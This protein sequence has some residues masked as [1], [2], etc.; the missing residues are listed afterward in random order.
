MSGRWPGWLFDNLGLKAF[1]LLLAALLYLHVLTDRTVEK[2]VYF[3]L[4]IESLPDSLALAKQVP[5]E[6]GV[7]LRGT[8]K[9]L[10]RLQYTRPKL[11]VSLAGVTPGAFRRPFAATDVPLEGAEAVDVLEITDPPQ[12]DLEVAPRLDRPVPIAP[13]LVGQPARGY[14]VSGPPTTRPPRVRL[15]GPAPWVQKQDSLVTAPISIAARRDTLEMM[16]ALI[17]PPAW[18]TVEPGSV[19]VRVPIE[20]AESREIR[21]SVEVRGIRG[22]IRADVRPEQVLVR[23]QGPRSA[24]KRLDEA[25]FGAYVDAGRRGRGIWHLP[26]TLTGPR[27]GAMVIEPDSVRVHLH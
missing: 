24:G 2:V 6:V 26:V 12:L 8:G 18:T 16:Q 21:V 22:E 25:R 23:W 14:V 7:R 4:E 19:F 3:P 1:A 11:E 13:V 27:S 17:P 9:Q 5:A 15:S 10:L 20:P